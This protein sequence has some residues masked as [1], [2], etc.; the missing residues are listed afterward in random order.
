VRQGTISPRKKKPGGTK[1]VHI[2]E[3]KGR[4]ERTVRKFQGEPEKKKK[5]GSGNSEKGGETIAESG[6]SIAVKSNIGMG[7]S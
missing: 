6:C 7:K 3:E 2:R 1:R 4:Q 5:Y